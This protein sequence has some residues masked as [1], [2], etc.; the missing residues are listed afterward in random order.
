MCQVIKQGNICNS[1]T[2]HV[3]DYQG[4]KKE[5]QVKIQG[6]EHIIG[7]ISHQFTFSKRGVLCTP[8]LGG[9]ECQVPSVSAF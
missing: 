5:K 9:N 6:N 2:I 4:N 8:T 7:L 1:V 3:R